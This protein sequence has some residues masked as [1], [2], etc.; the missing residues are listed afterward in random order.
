[1]KDISLRKHLPR[2]NKTN[3]KSIEKNS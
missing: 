2:N 1:M 3:Q